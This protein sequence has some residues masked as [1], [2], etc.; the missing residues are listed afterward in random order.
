MNNKALTLFFILLEIYRVCKGTL[1]VI[2]PPDSCGE[3]P[4]SYFETLEKGSLVYFSASTLNFITLFTL[5]CFYTVELR[6][7]HKIQHYLAVNDKLSTDTDSIHL[8]ID[9]LTEERKHNLS[10]V[11]RLY[12]HMG[13][14][15][16]F[17]V[18]VNILCSTYVMFFDY[19][20]HDGPID[21]VTNTVLLASKVYDILTILLADKHVYLSAYRKEKLQFNDVN[22]AKCSPLTSVP[23]SVLNVHQDNN[24]PV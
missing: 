19:F 6:R 15:T 22:P 7:E 18:S 3:H 23:H 24:P 13:Y 8:R 20:E 21:L 10:T 12:K 5:L 1:L 17:V 11:H 16:I 4:C 2:F 9:H 14:G